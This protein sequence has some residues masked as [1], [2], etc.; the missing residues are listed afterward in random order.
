LH[1]SDT[2]LD[3]LRELA[4]VATG[5]LAGNEVE[6]LALTGDIHGHHRAPLSGSIGPFAEL[7]K[8]IRVNDRRVAVLGN[9]DPADMA[10]ALDE[11]DFDVLANEPA[12]LSRGDDYIVLTGLDDVHR[13]YTPNALE[14]LSRSPGGFR[15]ALVHSAE[16]A[17]YAAAAGYA[18]YLCGQGNTDLEWRTFGSI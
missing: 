15:I 11:L 6:L 18:L 17:D 7:I 16:L 3:C 14:A 12:V 1:L 8:A 9:H 5:L 4:T 2:H 10:E 13:F